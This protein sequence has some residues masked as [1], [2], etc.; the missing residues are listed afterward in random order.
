MFVYSIFDKKGDFHTSQFFAKNDAEAVRIVGRLANDGHSD[1]SMYPSEFSL[2][3]IG[4]FNPDN[5]VITPLAPLKFVVEVLS[6][7]KVDKLDN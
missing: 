1:L 6:L 4:K 2:H 7:T 3:C 5:G